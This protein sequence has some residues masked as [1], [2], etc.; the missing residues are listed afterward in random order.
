MTPHLCKAIASRMTPIHQIIISNIA[1]T[2]RNGQQNYLINKSKMSYLILFEVATRLCPGGAIN[3]YL[4]H[5]HSRR[6]L[7]VEFQCII[8]LLNMRGY[9]PNEMAADFFTKDKLC[10]IT[11]SLTDELWFFTNS[12]INQIVLSKIMSKL[13]DLHSHNRSFVSLLW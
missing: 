5:A 12:S 9:L 1:Y 4:V 3:S 10:F 6:H 7:V 11:N 13:F 2:T 8:I